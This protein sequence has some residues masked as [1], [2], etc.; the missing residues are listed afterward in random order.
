MDASAKREH[1]EVAEQAHLNKKSLLNLTGLLKQWSSS[2]NSD[3][4]LEPSSDGCKEGHHA[5]A[6][7]IEHKPNRRG[8]RAL[9]SDDKSRTSRRYGTHSDDRFPNRTKEN[10]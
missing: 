8:V 5:A 7:T 4:L 3:N 2:G 10:E 6:I 9:R 1:P